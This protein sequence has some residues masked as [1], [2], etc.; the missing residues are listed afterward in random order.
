MQ[1]GL[2]IRAW[3][4]SSLLDW[5]SRVLEIEEVRKVIFSGEVQARA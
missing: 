5:L 3:R 2:Q 1:R 4:L